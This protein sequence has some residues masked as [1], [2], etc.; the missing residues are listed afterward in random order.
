MQCTYAYAYLCD[1]EE[2]T[3]ELIF[4]AVGHIQRY[5]SRAVGEG[6][7]G[8]CLPGL[9]RKGRYSVL[10]NPFRKKGGKGRVAFSSGVHPL[11]RHHTPTW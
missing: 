1:I 7:K 2:I 11:R 8:R 6:K 3:P 9:A 10:K 5:V 4:G